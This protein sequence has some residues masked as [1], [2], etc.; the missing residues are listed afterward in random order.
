MLYFADPELKRRSDTAPPTNFI[1]VENGLVV[2]QR[3]AD[4]TSNTIS[5]PET[6]EV[7]PTERRVI[8]IER[9]FLEELAS[10]K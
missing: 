6:V 1:A 8:A 3:S 7:T 5:S 4:R 9:A 2:P 10:D